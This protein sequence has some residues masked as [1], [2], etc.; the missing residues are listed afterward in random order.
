MLG[1][2]GPGQRPVAPGVY[3]VTPERTLLSAI[4][5]DGNA[6]FIEGEV[7]KYMVT[8]IVQYPQ[9]VGLLKIVQNHLVLLAVAL[10][11]FTGVDFKS[12]EFFDAFGGQFFR[13][14][15]IIQF[16]VTG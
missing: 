14:M 8:I 2:G 12:D 15:G 9:I 16:F 11:N 13:E 4:E 3:S 6:Q 7:V 10:L 5:I 1:F